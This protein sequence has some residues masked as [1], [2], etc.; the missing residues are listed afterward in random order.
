MAE[1]ILRKPGGL[2]GGMAH[3]A[4]LSSGEWPGRQTMTHCF[5]YHCTLFCRQ[6]EAV[7]PRAIGLEEKLPCGQSQCLGPS[8]IR[9][10]LALRFY[11]GGK[12]HDP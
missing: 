8:L 11:L 6:R 5:E 7:K 10:F 4:A 1:G 9:G 12:K 2:A 3:E